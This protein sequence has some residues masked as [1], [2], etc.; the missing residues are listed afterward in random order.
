[1]VLYFSNSLK[2][3]LKIL[4]NCKPYVVQSTE[5]VKPGKGQAFLRVKLRNLLTDQ[6]IFKTFKSTDVLQLADVLEITAIYL[7]NDNIS[8]FF[9][10][11]KTFEHISVLKKYLFNCE[12]WLCNSVNCIITLWNNSPVKVQL[13]NFIYLKVKKIYN[14]IKGNSISTVTKIVKLTNGIKIRAPIFIKKGDILKIDTR[15]NQY[16]CRKR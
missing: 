5:F 3:G 15:S 2:S 6:L 8:W 14:N 1:M 7:Y 12:K 9:M 13:D 10:N 4:V 16:I 11:Q